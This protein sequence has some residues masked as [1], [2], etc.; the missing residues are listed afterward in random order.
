MCLWREFM[1]IDM[2]P[3]HPTRGSWT[4]TDPVALMVSP[5]IDLRVGLSPNYGQ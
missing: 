1:T 3:L 5:F 2:T 4:E